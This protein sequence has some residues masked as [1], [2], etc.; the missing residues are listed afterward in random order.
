MK[1]HTFVVFIARTFASLLPQSTTLSNATYLNSGQPNRCS[2]GADPALLSRDI[3]GAGTER[4]T[5]NPSTIV[6]RYYHQASRCTQILF[7]R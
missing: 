5:I 7:G 3:G 1:R 6:Y 2:T 4:A